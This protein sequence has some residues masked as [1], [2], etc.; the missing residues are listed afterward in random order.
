MSERG[1]RVGALALTLALV[2]ALGLATTWRYQAYL[3]Y[4]DNPF[5]Y[6]RVDLDAFRHRRQSARFPIRTSDDLEANLAI[7]LERP[8]RC[9]RMPGAIVS[10]VKLHG[11]FS[12]WEKSYGVLDLGFRQGIWKNGEIHV[13][14]IYMPDY[15]LRYYR[16]P[17]TS[18]TGDYT[19]C[20]FAEHLG[21]VEFRQRI[22]RAT[23]APEYGYEYDDYLTTFDHYDTRIHRLGGTLRFQ[24]MTNFGLRAEYQYRAARARGPVPDVSYGQHE[25]G[26]SVVTRPRRLFRLSLEA[27]YKFARRAYTTGNS[28]AI[29]PSHA[30]RTDN[31]ESALLKFKYRLSRTVLC[32]DY[33]LEWREVVS[34]SS[35]E[36]DDV[37]DYRRSR[38]GLGITYESSKE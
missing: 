18:D 10:G 11:F 27:G 29:D 34:A 15:L 7:G 20:R 19:A 33:G 1:A 21:K 2:P 32:L 13:N 17:Q 23:I 3:F 6:S 28:V 26:L 35:S 31:L 9:F 22:G 4:D 24:L 25:V 5:R 14:Y 36:I 16:N 30:E 37:K 12:N 38:L 8:T